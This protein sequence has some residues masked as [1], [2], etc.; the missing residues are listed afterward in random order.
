MQS[1]FAV[2]VSSVAYPALPYLSISHHKR[3]DFQ[4]NV[5]EHK[6]CTSIFSTKLYK[7]FFYSKET[8]E[9]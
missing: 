3:H 8:S 1:A 6:M 5:T 7:I 4:K 9:L 2:L